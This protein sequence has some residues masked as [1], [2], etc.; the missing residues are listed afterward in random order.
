MRWRP[1]LRPS[2]AITA[3]PRPLD[4]GK[5]IKRGKGR[6]NKGKSDMKTRKGRDEKGRREIDD[7]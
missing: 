4:L 1:E 6:G 2:P 5:G 7:A 3:Y